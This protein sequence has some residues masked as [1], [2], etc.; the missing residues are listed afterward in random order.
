MKTKKKIPKSLK[1]LEF[2]LFPKLVYFLENPNKIIF[3]R[4]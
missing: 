2:V 1:N 3:C 4:L